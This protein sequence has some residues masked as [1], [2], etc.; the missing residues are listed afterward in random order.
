MEFAHVFV[1]LAQKWNLDHVS[2]GVSSGDAGRPCLLRWGVAGGQA[3][4]PIFRTK[5]WPWEGRVRLC[6]GSRPPWPGRPLLTEDK[7][8]HGAQARAIPSGHS[9]RCHGTQTQSSWKVEFICAFLYT[10]PGSAQ[11]RSDLD[12]VYPEDGLRGH[13]NW[14]RDGT[15]SQADCKF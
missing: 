9:A 3:Q 11:T 4:Q 14:G 8:R 10:A 15:W 6:S 13:D 5:L 12:T 7:L 1:H 2:P